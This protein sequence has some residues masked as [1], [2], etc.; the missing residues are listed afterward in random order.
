VR[1]LTRVGETEQLG[2]RGA[3]RFTR[4]YQ[5]EPGLAL[6]FH[7]LYE[8]AFGPL[9]V[10]ALARQVLTEVEFHAQMADG[11]VMKYVAWDDDDRPVGL[12]TLTNRLETVPWISPEYF[13][14]RYPDHWERNAV[15]YF[16]FVLTHPTER[17]SRF[18]DQ[19]VEVGIG[20][21]VE[22]HAIC[23]WD[24]CAYNDATLGIG[25]RL[26]ESFERLTGVTARL[27]DT[28]NYYTLDLT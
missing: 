26:V 5:V 12:C 20:E 28:Q 7:D 2:R 9:R 8:T 11:A 1:G 27:A 23:A 6:A 13:A 16:G 25:P 3:W 15:W 24:M 19:L 22:Q 18:V 4:E 14:D 21:L 17:R 10:Q